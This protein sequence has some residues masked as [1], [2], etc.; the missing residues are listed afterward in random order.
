[1]ATRDDNAEQIYAHSAAKDAAWEEDWDANEALAQAREEI[2]AREAAAQAPAEGAPAPAAEEGEDD[3]SVFMDMLKSFARGV[4]AELADVTD[5]AFDAGEAAMRG[6]GIPEAFLQEIRDYRGGNLRDQ[7]DQSL[8]TPETTAGAVTQ[9]ITGQLGL[10]VPGLVALRSAQIIGKGAGLAGAATGAFGLPAAVATGTHRPGEGTVA[11]I[12]TEQGEGTVFDNVFTRALSIDEDDSRLEELA[13]VFG[14]DIILSGAGEGLV[15]GIKAGAKGVKAGSSGV[16]QSVQRVRGVAKARRGVT[17]EADEAAVIGADAVSTDEVAEGVEAAVKAEEAAALTNG[18]LDQIKNAIEVSIA[19]GEDVSVL[20]ELEADL[21]IKAE[22]AS[23][24][25]SDAAQRIVEFTGR[26]VQDGRA[27]EA[28]RQAA[29]LGAD[30]DAALGKAASRAVAGEAKPPRTRTVWNHL[31]VTGDVADDLAAKI[32]DG[33]FDGAA[34]TFG[35]TLDNTNLSRI[36][37]DDSLKDVLSGLAKEFH[38]S[39]NS[40]VSHLRPQSVAASADEARKVITK[41]AKDNHTTEEA[42]LRSHAEQFD[43][44]FSV[45]AW[46]NALRMTEAGLNAK[47]GKLSDIMKDPETANLADGERLLR[48]IQLL[49]NVRDRRAGFTTDVARALGAHK[50]ITHERDYLGAAIKGNSQ[51]IA[52]L[53]KLIDGAGGLEKVSQLAESLSLAIDED[54]VGHIADAAKLDPTLGDMFFNM[55]IGNVLSAGPTQSVNIVTPA[56]QA[57]LWNPTMHLF[58]AAAM[59]LKNGNPARFRAAQ[60]SLNAALSAAR[61]GLVLPG[62]FRNMWQEQGI[63]AATRDLGTRIGGSNVGRAFKQSRRVSGRQGQDLATDAQIPSSSLLRGEGLAGV[64]RAGG[65]VHIPLSGA[66]TKGGAHVPLLRPMGQKNL[67]AAGDY[68]AARQG[69]AKVLDYVGRVMELPGK[70]L[71]AGDE[72][73]YGMNFHGQLHSDLIEEGAGRGLTGARLTQH[74]EE[75]LADMQGLASLKRQIE[76]FGDPGGIK[77]AKVDRLERIYESANGS[78]ERGTYTENGG[79][80][81]DAMMKL[82]RAMPG[83]RWFMPFMRTPLNLVKRGA[84]DFNPAGQ[85]VQAGHSLLK[86]EFDEAAKKAARTAFVGGIYAAVW[87]GAMS[88]RIQGGGPTNPAQRELWLSE[89]DDQGR[90]LNVPYSILIGDQR[91]SANRFDP[92]AMPIFMMVDAMEIMGDEDDITW[93]ETSLKISNALGEAAKSRSFVEGIV[94]LVHLFENPERYGRRMVTSIVENTVVP[95]SRLWANLERGGL[96]VPNDL[97]A[98]LGG[99]GAEGLLKDLVT[100]RPGRQAIQD[101]QPGLQGLYLQ[102]GSTIQSDL[103]AGLSEGFEEV[104]NLIHSKKLHL[105]RTPN[106]NFWGEVRNVPMTMGPNMVSP[107]VGSDATQTDPVSDEMLRLGAGISTQ[108]RFGNIAGVKLT[109]EQQYRFQLL[110]A[111]PANNHPDAYGDDP[112]IHEAIS[113]EMFVDGDPAQG[114]DDVWMERGDS[115]PD[116]TT[117]NKVIGG[118]EARLNTVIGRYMKQARRQVLEEFPELKGQ[119]EAVE[120]ERRDA[121]W[122]EEEEGTTETSAAAQR[123]LDITR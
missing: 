107:F 103:P 27:T 75:G 55:F 92:I 114:F 40:H 58:D 2:N 39:P 11:N 57:L 56:L 20:R 52:E 73:T 68:I 3:P 77:Q 38:N 88:G 117:G 67:N 120:K 99:D 15:A 122:N 105:G 22:T 61:A 8:G 47:V 17:Q 26:G 35:A 109:P 96:P 29:G 25:A 106:L 65:K 19:K 100:G 6:L 46:V 30:V 44:K 95:G 62:S 97:V 91:I 28:L 98:N 60:A 34:D 18:A 49:A 94:N 12:A 32:R 66:F 53:E 110:F 83:L 23:R 119:V 54:A 51:R 76:T 21:A 48:S 24:E 121:Q 79:P 115:R 108:Q 113:Q 93:E 64:V 72:L 111:D 69:A 5:N 85:A 86:G 84:A 42:I 78:A 31:Q 104:W 33:D 74:V 90:P 89:T 63:K 1:M 13:K 14:E 101:E 4:P 123:L 70:M 10:I 80:A 102:L 112:T 71:A 116:P 45:T 9:G 36:D 118:K 50:F 16:V 7:V 59:T 37:S 87:N 82:R 41:L 43:G 81:L